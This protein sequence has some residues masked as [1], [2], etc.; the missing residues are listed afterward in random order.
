LSQKDKGRSASKDLENKNRNTE[1]HPH[2][3]S[4]EETWSCDTC[5]LKFADENDKLL[6]CEYCGHHRCVSCLGMT[7][8]VYKAISG[9]PDLPW[10]CSSCMQKSLNVIRET[11]SIETRCSDF[12]AEFEKKMG[13][14]LDKIEGEISNVKEDI[15]FMKDSMKQH[16]TTGYSALGSSEKDSSAAQSAA[17]ELLGSI[18]NTIDRRNNVVFYNVKESSS[19]IKNE[20]LEHDKEE[21]IAIG[22]AIGIELKA[23]DLGNT[24]RQGK[25]DVTRKVH[26]EE[27][28]E[29][30][31]SHSLSKLRLWS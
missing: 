21:V 24:R 11:K 26:G 4:N 19:N 8:T 15:A 27:Y 10:F 25:K 30:Y 7:K 2:P 23:E 20:K 1:E 18:Q 22:H 16:I 17:K 31:W 28:L 6:S 29:F 3:P 9:R 13:Q 5:E 12:L 14:R